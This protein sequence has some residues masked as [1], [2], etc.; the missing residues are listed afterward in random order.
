ASREVTRRPES[1]WS[2]LDLPGF[3]DE[4]NDFEEESL[5]GKQPWWRR[6]SVLIAAAAVILLGAVLTPIALRRSHKTPVTYTTSTVRQGTLTTTVS[7]TGPLQAATFNVNFSGSG[8]LTEIDVAVGQQVTSGQVLAKLDPTSLQD[9]VNA[10]QTSLNNS[11]TS[12]SNAYNQGNAQLNAAYQQEQNTILNTCN[13]ITDTTKKSSCIDNA[14]AQYD[15]TQAQVTT[16]ESNAEAQV[17]S[18]QNALNTAIHNLGNATL[19]APHDGIVGAV[20]GQVG[21]TP[22]AGSSGGG[23]TFI[24]IVDLSALQVTADVNE[25]DI[26]KIAAGQRVTFTVSAYGTRR[27]TGVVTTV[28]PLGTSTSSVVTY[29]VTSSVDA[30]DLQG[31][32]LLPAMTANVTIVTA[33]RTGVLL[34]P[35][36]AITFARTQVTSGA[37]TRASALTAFRQAAQMLQAA[38]SSDATAQQDNLQAAFVLERAKN[39]WVVKPV[40]V[41]LTNGTSYEVLSGLSAGETIVTG[42]SGAGATTTTTTGGGLFGG[43]GGRFGGGG[44][45]GGGRGGAGGGGTAGG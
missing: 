2:R 4:T 9:A 14:Q 36:T 10:A 29:P 6:R 45:G 16:S 18:A 1:D 44:A 15:Q 12:R 31:V 35:A 33:Q 5:G 24:Q 20:N 25:A 38:T 39:Q 32:R 27:F 3:S 19:K 28:S 41:G 22:G 13:N 30:T 23:S 40:V 21:G 17:S 34:V 8:T 42:Q 11:Y 43:G 37:V 26:G 7:A